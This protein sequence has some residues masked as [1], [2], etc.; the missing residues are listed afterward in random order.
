MTR[1]LSRWLVPAWVGI[2]VGALLAATI[3][4]VLLS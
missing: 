4:R 3:L 2:S 1:F